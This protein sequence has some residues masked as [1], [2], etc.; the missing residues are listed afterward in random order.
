MGKLPKF[1]AEN[2]DHNI[3]VTSCLKSVHFKKPVTLKSLIDKQTGINEQDWKKGLT[4]L[5]YLLSKLINE[6]SKLKIH[7]NNVGREF[8]KDNQ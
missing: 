4:L 8:S 5:P 3:K 7:T 1:N 2:E 6:H